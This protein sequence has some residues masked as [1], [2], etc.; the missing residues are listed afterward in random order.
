[1]YKVTQ[2][3]GCKCGNVQLKGTVDKSITIVAHDENYVKLVHEIERKIKH[4]NLI[5][6]EK[7]LEQSLSCQTYFFIRQNDQ[8]YIIEP[9]T[10]F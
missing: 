6:Q 8:C 2:M 5:F 3:W 4:P 9:V 10:F 1:V 7:D